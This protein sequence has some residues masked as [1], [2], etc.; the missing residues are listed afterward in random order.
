MINGFKKGVPQIL[1]IVAFG[2][3]LM[4]GMRLAEWAFQKPPTKLLICLSDQDGHI[5]NCSDFDDYVTNSTN[6][7]QPTAPATRR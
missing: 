2:F 3:L 4:S 6:P 1:A 7:N 5:G